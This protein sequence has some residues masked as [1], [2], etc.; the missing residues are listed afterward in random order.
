MLYDSLHDKLLPLP[1]DTLV[2]PAHGAGSLCGKNLST[3]TVSTIGVQR[4]YNYALQPMSRERFIEIVTT[5]QPD[6]PSYFTYDAV[7]NARERPTLEQAL[8]RELRP[9]TLEHGCWNWS[10]TGAQLLDTRDPP[11]SRA[12]TCAGSRQHRPRRLVRDLVRDDSRPGPPGRADR[13]A[14]P[15]GRG[16]D[17]ARP[18]RVRQPSPATSPA[19]CSALRRRARAASSGSSGSPP[20]SLAELLDVRAGTARWSTYAHRA[21]MASRTGSTAPS[22][23][24]SRGWRTTWQVF[25]ARWPIVVYCAS[26]YR[27]AIASS[28]MCRADKRAVTDLVGGIGAW[29]STGLSTTPPEP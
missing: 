13:R 5:D 3:D 24:R 8:E 2:Y 28:L 21:R 15:R 16:G 11:S 19:G 1:D 7:L 25:R 4:R 9:L 10:T 23:C 14:G 20:R 26:G 22:T 27:S 29:E 17:A 12:R 18:D 6:A